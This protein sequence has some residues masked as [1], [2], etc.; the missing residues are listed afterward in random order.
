MSPIIIRPI[1]MVTPYRPTGFWF[2]V[3]KSVQAVCEALWLAGPVEAVAVFAF[4]GICLASLAVTGPMV[5]GWLT[6][7]I[8]GMLS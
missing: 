8:E 7:I 5:L 1:R 3:R 6:M 4:F 2:R